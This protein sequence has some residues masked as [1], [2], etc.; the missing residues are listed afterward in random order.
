MAR[1]QTLSILNQ[2]LQSI[3]SI[4]TVDENNNTLIEEKETNNIGGDYLTTQLLSNNNSGE[5]GRRERGCEKVG[6]ERGGGGGGEKG[7]G[8][9][10]KGDGGGDVVFRPAGMKKN[11]INKEYKENKEDKRRKDR[12]DSV[13]N[14]KS[15]TVGEV[16]MIA[17]I[18]AAIQSNLI[19]TFQID[20]MSIKHQDNSVTI[21]SSSSTTTFSSEP[22][23]ERSSVSKI[24]YPSLT[25]TNKEKTFQITFSMVPIFE[26][27]VIYAMKKILIDAKN[28]L[29]TTNTQMTTS[30]V[31]DNDNN[32]Q[33]TKK[34]KI[35][36]LYVNPNDFI[37]NNSDMVQQCSEECSDSEEHSEDYEEEYIRQFHSGSLN[38]MSNKNNKNEKNERDKKGMK[39]ILNKNK[40]NNCLNSVII[41]QYKTKFHELT[42]RIEKTLLDPLLFEK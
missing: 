38:C 23:S 41:G 17:I 15:L 2:I 36:T 37:F 40:L 30:G 11:I 21:K 10:E 34:K 29:S 28:I 13:F 12:K 42:L 7:G 1:H 14:I 25:F 26:E 19:P 4:Q 16:M 22:S 5:E 6:E 33:K 9:E 24:T 39:K 32:I 8:G 31:S 3:K 35:Q 27:M 18:V 20:Y